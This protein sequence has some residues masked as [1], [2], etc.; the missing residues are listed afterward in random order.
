MCQFAAPPDY[1]R[2]SDPVSPALGPF[3]AIIDTIL[4]ADKQVHVKKRHTSVRI[5]ERLRALQ[6]QPTNLKLL[7]V[8]ELGYVSF[9]VIGAELLSEIFGWRH[10]GDIELAV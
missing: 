6:K 7:T 2:T 8:D 4:E 5:R 3:V 9:S 1:R 10:T